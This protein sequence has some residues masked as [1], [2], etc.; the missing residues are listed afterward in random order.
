MARLVYDKPLQ[1]T[2]I[3]KSNINQRLLQNLGYTN[4]AGLKSGAVSVAE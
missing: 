4:V 1:N 2:L 3:C